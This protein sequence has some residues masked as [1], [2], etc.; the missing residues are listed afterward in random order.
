M[1]KA[2]LFLIAGILVFGSVSAAGCSVKSKSSK[3]SKS[4]FSASFSGKKKKKKSVTAL[5]T[6]AGLSDS[7]ADD[8][9]GVLLECGLITK[10]ISEV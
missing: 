3:S 2:L 10:D 1:K 4:S 7:E 8:A 9:F 6:G 5:K